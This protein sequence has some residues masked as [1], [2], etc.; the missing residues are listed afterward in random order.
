V[1]HPHAKWVIQ[2]YI[3]ARTE[4]VAATVDRLEPDGSREILRFLSGP[5]DTPEDI[6]ALLIELI[7]EAEW[8]GI[9]LTLPGSPA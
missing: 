6:L 7:E 8:R 9:Q 2:L 3:S 5:F 4:I 1:A